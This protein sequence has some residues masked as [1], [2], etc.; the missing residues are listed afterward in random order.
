MYLYANDW[1]QFEPP[2][3][4]VV[5]AWVEEAN[6]DNTPPEELLVMWNEAV[7]IGLGEYKVSPLVQ[8]RE[9]IQWSEMCQNVAWIV[10]ACGLAFAG[11][12]FF[13]RRKA[14]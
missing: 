7:K 10:V 2:P 13:L 4:E 12:S 11:S 1:K 9:A 8:A 5:D 6:I 3:K 14:N